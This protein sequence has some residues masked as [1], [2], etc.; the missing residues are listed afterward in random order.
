MSNF[1]SELLPDHLVNQEGSKRAWS[2]IHAHY[3]LLFCE[4]MTAP[5][6]RLSHP[7]VKGN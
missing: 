5:H 4:A 2:L 3:R 1:L 7:H 6:L